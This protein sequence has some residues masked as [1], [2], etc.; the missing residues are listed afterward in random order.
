[1]FYQKQLKRFC[2]C[3][4]DT[5]PSLVTISTIETKPLIGLSPQDDPESLVS[6][7]PSS[8]ISENRSL[9][10]EQS[11]YNSVSAHYSRSTQNGIKSNQLPFHPYDDTS[12]SACAISSMSSH[13]HM[14]A[15]SAH[16]RSMRM[17]MRYSPYS[18]QTY[19][20][21]SVSPTYLP[22]SHGHLYNYPSC[23]GTQPFPST[24]AGFG[25]S[26]C[27][28]VPTVVPASSDLGSLEVTA[29]HTEHAGDLESRPH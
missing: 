11:S 9:Q 18:R 19:P 16:A 10:D 7:M 22:H 3:F 25:F 21:S 24:Q 14:K 23:N 8:K 5:S 2:F 28:S 29:P 13:S 17:D 4:S 26:P 6:E 20:M 15:Q 1:M 27:V 12:S